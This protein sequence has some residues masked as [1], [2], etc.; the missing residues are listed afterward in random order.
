MNVCRL[1]WKS[2]NSP[3]EFWLGN[4][5]FRRSVVCFLLSKGSGHTQRGRT[6]QFALAFRCFLQEFFKSFLR[7]SGFSLPSGRLMLIDAQFVER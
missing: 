2:E 1:A 6:G 3:R 5:R 4:G 7:N